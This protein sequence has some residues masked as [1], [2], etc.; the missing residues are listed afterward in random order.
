MVSH[1]D[2]CNA[3]RN[4][5]FQPPPPIHT[6]PT[7]LVHAHPND[8]AWEPISY[9]EVHRAIFALNQHKALGPSQINYVALRWAWATDPIPIFLLVSKCANA[10]YHPQVWRKTVAVALRKPKKPDYS[11]PHAY[12]LIQSEECLGKVLESVV[13]CRLSHMIHEHNLVPATQFGGHPGSSTVDAA[14]TFTHDIEAAH[15][16]G[17]VT[18]SLTI[19]I[20]GFFDYVNHNKLTSIMRRKRIPLPM[21]KWVS[22]FLSNREAAICLDGRISDSRPIENGILQGSPI[23]PALSIL[24]ASP[25]YEEFQ[26]RL[27][28]RYVHRAPPTAKLTPTTLVGYIDDVNIYTSS[29]SLLQNIATLRADFVTILH[30]LH[31]LGLSIDFIKCALAHFTRKHNID[32]P[33]ITLPGP[34]GDIVITH[35][36]TMKWLG[37][38]FDSKLLFNEHVKAATNKA[39]NIAKGLTMLGNTVRGLHQCLLRT[40]YGACVRSVMTYASLVWWDGKKKHANKL[41]WVQNACLCHICAAFHTTPIHALEIDSATPPT[42]LVLDRL[43][44]NAASRLHKLAHTSP[45]HLRLPREWQGYDL[46][47][48]A[49]ALPPDKFHPRSRKPPKTTCL[50]RLAL[51]S[52]PAIPHID[53]LA[54]PP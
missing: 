37:I 25:V 5:L 49:P 21:V 20:K 45:I 15:N 41:T 26:A 29:T 53:I 12:H 2:K 30:I 10:G 46:A 23:S 14:L 18:T 51:C 34:D 22:S 52:S 4:M 50:T 9:A 40:I 6:D 33:D 17:L 31:G 44:S 19:D 11:N 8:I 47:Y 7:E 1:E 38:T 28:T 16:H 35:S 54:I 43:S 42:P 27:A 24:Y 13:A 36:N 32:F 48:P 39:E 3:L